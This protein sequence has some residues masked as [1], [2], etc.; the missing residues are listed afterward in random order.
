MEFDERK[1][2]EV[3]EKVLC[4]EK[5]SEKFE[6]SYSEKFSHLKNMD[7]MENLEKLK[8]NPFFS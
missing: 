3:G 6:F 7:G 4:V 8:L 2:F 1:S 5:T